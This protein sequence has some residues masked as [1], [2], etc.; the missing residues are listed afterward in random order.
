MSLDNQLAFHQE[1]EQRIQQRMLMQQQPHGGQHPGQQQQQ[2]QQYMPPTSQ[3]GF[4]PSGGSGQF[5]GGFQQQVPMLAVNGGYFEG[6]NGQ[7]PGE[8]GAKRKHMDDGMFGMQGPMHGGMHPMAMW[9]DAQAWTSRFLPGFDGGRLPWRSAKRATEQICNLHLR[10]RQQVQRACLL[11]RQSKLKCDD[12]RPC[13]RCVKRGTEGGCVSWE[14]VKN[15]N[16][17]EAKPEA[18]SALSD[19]SDAVN[20]NETGTSE[21]TPAP[22]SAVDDGSGTGGSPPVAKDTPAD[23]VPESGVATARAQEA[24]AH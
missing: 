20:S 12:Q 10:K 5:G 17:G 1:H 24:Y 9:D 18:P 14:G 11:C 8:V 22:D 23:K 15:A 13:S 4:A 3:Q 6:H 21:S 7:F 16:K 2:Q 19:T